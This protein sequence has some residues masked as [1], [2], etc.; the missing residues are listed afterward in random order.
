MAS[1]LSQNTKRLGQIL[2]DG[3][4]GQV[5]E[6]GQRLEGASSSYWPLVSKLIV[7]DFSFERSYRKA[8][9]LFRGSDARF[10]AVDGSLDQNLIGGLAVFWAGAYAATGTISYS[11]DRTPNVVYDTGFLEK[12]HGLASCVPIYV[13]SIPE[14][15]PQMALS[16]AEGQ[17]S[18]IL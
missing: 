18:H 3:A 1:L 17:P 13:Y 9:D 14:V 8:Q 12:G 16:Q 15:E 4:E 2:R 6:S 7:S 10:A 11:K 5:G